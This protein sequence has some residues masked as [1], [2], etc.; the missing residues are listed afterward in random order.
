VRLPSGR[1]L[2][3]GGGRRAE[4]YDPATRS[5]RPAGH[6]GAALSFATATVLRNGR[7]LV[8]GGYDRGIAVTSHAWVA[9]PR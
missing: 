1:V 2:V 3:A 9:A 4:L 5:F 6:A 8:A 7:V